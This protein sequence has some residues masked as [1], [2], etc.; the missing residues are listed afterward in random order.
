MLVVYFGQLCTLGFT[1]LSA[2]VECDLLLPA[3]LHLKAI[4]DV[5]NKLEHGHLG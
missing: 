3:S 1:V 5:N 4:G 2:V